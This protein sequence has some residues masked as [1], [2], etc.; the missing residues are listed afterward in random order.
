MN[1]TEPFLGVIRR[2]MVSVIRSALDEVLK[3]PLGQIRADIQGL[4][5][6]I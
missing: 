4:R 6:D 5:S 3:E 1:L 2:L